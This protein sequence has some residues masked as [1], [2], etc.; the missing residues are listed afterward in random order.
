MLQ[1]LTEVVQIQIQTVQQAAVLKI[2]Q[3]LQADWDRCFFC[4]CL[5]QEAAA[6]KRGLWQGLAKALQGGSGH[7]LHQHA[8]LCT[9]LPHGTA[10]QGLRK[11]LESRRC[12]KKI[13]VLYL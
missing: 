3:S 12:C 13:R 4:G 8:G 1:L 10:E 7:L 9:A 11:K 2:P 5:W 6:A